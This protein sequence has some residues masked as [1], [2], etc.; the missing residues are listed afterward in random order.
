MAVRA[1]IFDLDGTLADTEP[2]H[3]EAFN[4]V[5]RRLGSEIGR[6]DYFRR[7]VGF[8]DR[9]CFTLLMSE[10]RMLAGDALI[11]ELIAQKTAVYQALIAQRQLLFPGAAEFVRRCADRFPLALVTGTLRIEAEM[12]LRKAQIRDLFAEIVA[13]EDVKQGKPAPDGFKVALARLSCILGPQP[14]LAAA[15]CLAIEDTAVGIEAARQAGMRVLGVAQTVCAIELAAAD[16]VRPAV[17]ATD[18]DEILRVFA[19]LD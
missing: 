8:D 1:I 16:L 10:H 13:A 4:T 2:L 6:D 7:L 19:T 15:E 17:A 9:G 11:G 3:F 14:P 12:I 18:L 5:L